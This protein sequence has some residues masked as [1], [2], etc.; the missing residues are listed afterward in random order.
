MTTKNPTLNLRTFVES[1]HDDRD[2]DDDYDDDETKTFYIKIFTRLTI[3]I[4]IKICVFELN[5]YLE[6]V[7]KFL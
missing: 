2:D 4:D 7:P 5:I 1:Q 6:Q 3:K